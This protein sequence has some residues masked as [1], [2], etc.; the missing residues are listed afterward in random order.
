MPLNANEATL[1]YADEYS[2]MAETYDRVVAPRFEPIARTV[3]ELL[4]PKSG[5]LLLD[6]ATGTGVLACLLAPLVAPQTVV[7][8]D[9]AD[10]AI[11]VASFRA[12]NAGIRNVRFEMM[13][14]RNIVYRG[15]LFDKVGSNLG[16]P[17]LGYDRTF[18][19]VHRLLKPGGL[20]VF[21]EWD[22]KPSF[23]E[24]VYGELLPRYRTTTPSKE[25]AQL[26][27][28]VALNRSDPEARALKN[29][30]AVR[31]KLESF[32]FADVRD[33]PRTFVTRFAGLEDFLAFEA[34][35][36]WDERELREMPPEHRRTFEEEFARRL[37]DRV[38]PDGFD[39]TWTIHFM[40]AHA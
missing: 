16:I 15:Q 22:A 11:G 14:A 39:E 2:R 21:S 4:G 23:A 17:N 8:I 5:E 12:G 3:V 24:G 1:L 27:E 10:E 26:R 35:W 19:E 37:G 31:K 29:P 30:A 6:L 36:G 18:Y 34:G 25:L 38:G 40:V 20:F 7:A 32:G 28:A 9:L 13:D 33:V